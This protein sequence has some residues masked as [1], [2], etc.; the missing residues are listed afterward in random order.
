MSRDPHVADKL[1]QAI[2]AIKAGDKATGQRLLVDFLKGDQHNEAAWLWM[3]ATFDDAEKRRRCLETVLQINP[4]SEPAKCGLAQ[5]EPQ[6]ELPVFGTTSRQ[7]LVTPTRKKPWY[8]SYGFKILA[9]LFFTPLW[10][11]IVL[12]D[13]ATSASVKVVAVT[14]L[15]LYVLMC[16]FVCLPAMYSGNVRL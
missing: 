7:A 5:L 9:F 13:P 1:Q 2:A 10:T 11:I 12:D 8:R 4:D 14:L 16:V 3:A 6:V 15:V